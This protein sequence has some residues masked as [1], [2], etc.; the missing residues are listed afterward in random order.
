MKLT[1]AAGWATQKLN[2]GTLLEATAQ[3]KQVTLLEIITRSLLDLPTRLDSSQSFTQSLGA[4]STALAST[5]GRM[6]YTTGGI[7][8]H[9]V[10]SALLFK[11]EDK[12]LY[13]AIVF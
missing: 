3:M 12:P 10:L 6:F 4:V 5:T 1:L 11:E 7:R 9:L 13:R 8:K 2:S